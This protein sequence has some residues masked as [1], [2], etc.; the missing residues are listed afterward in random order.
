MGEAAG[1]PTLIQTAPPAATFKLPPVVHNARGETRRVGFEF[2]YACV[3]PK[4]WAIIVEHV[5]GGH[6][7]VESAYARQ[8]P[9]T[10]FGDV[11][12][13]QISGHCL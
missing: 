12:V 4:A 7:V 10:R 6:I 9:G 3:G 8:M 1:A 5:F 11:P 2:E 13:E